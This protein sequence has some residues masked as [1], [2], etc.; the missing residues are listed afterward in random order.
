MSGPKLTDEKLTAVCVILGSI[1]DSLLFSV[2]NTS[3]ESINK[4]SL[5]VNFAFL[6]VILKSIIPTSIHESENVVP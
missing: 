5:T 1:I 6:A 3:V 4:E 2:V